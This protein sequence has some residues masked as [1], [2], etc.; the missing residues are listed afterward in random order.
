N[1]LPH[2]NPS[3]HVDIFDIIQETRV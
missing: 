2:H 3:N 1:G